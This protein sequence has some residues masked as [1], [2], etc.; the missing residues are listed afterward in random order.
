MRHRTALLNLGIFAVLLLAAS[1]ARATYTLTPLCNGTSAA[2]VAPGESFVIALNLTSNAEDTCD[3][4][5]FDVVFS[6]PGLILDGYAWGGNYHTS[7]YDNSAPPHYE[8]FILDDPQFETGQLLTLNMT[9]PLDYTPIPDAIA[10]HVAPGTF[11]LGAATFTPDAGPDAT[12]CIVPEP[13][14]FF[15]AATGGLVFGAFSLR[16]WRQYRSQ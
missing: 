8:N 6:S 15:L 13:S 4:A 16:R 2:E 7:I 12:L 1:L 5:I 14:T 10:I 3:S 9:V 11:A